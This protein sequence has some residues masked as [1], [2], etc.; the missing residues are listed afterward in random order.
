MSDVDSSV[1]PA[2]PA[3]AERQTVPGAWW[4]G[5]GLLAA[6]LVVAVWAF[7][8][9][10]W[11]LGTAVVVFGLTALGLWGWGRARIVVADGWFAVD[12]ATIETRY[13]GEVVPLTGARSKAALREGRTGEWLHLRPWLGGAVRCE[14]T[15]PA[16]RHTSW[17]VAT[18]HP[19]RLATVLNAPAAHETTGSAR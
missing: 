11:G 3:Y 13:L 7:L 9:D 6:S 10:R 8:G 5:L 19:D 12:G 2:S 15:D 16:D 14:L 17:L 18:R 4:A 1:T